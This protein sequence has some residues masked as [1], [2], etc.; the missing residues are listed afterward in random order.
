MHIADEVTESIFPPVVTEV[1][2]WGS[3]VVNRGGNTVQVDDRFEVFAMGDML[4]DPDT[5]ENLGRLESTV[6]IARITAVKPKYSLAEMI[7][8][9]A[10]IVRG[11]VLR[12]FLGDLDE[13]SGRD[14][15]RNSEALRPG[16]E[17]NYRRIDSDRDRDGMPDYLNRDAQTRD[18]NKDGLPDYLNRDNLRRR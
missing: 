2:G 3:F 7:T 18:S 14:A 12:R 9:A 11:M 15:D 1:T 4:M 13:G 5:G 17:R 6:G 10:A 16:D 8:D